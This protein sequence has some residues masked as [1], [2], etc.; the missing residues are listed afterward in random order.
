MFDPTL[1]SMPAVSSTKVMP[2]AMT[3]VKLA[4]LTMLASESRRRGSAAP[5]GRR[6]GSTA[7]KMI[8]SRVA[9][10]ESAAR[11][12][13]VAGHAATPAARK[14]A[15]RMASLSNALAGERADDLAA[16][17][18][19]D[20]V[21]HRHRLLDLGGDEAGCRSRRRRAG[22]SSCRSRSLAATS[23]PR[24]GSSRRMIAGPAISH[25]AMHH[26]LLVAARQ[27]L[28]R[29][30]GDRSGL[31]AQGRGHLAGAGGEASVRR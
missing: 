4:C 27:A 5:A 25:L 31:D 14:A 12:G 18:H 29:R 28:G 26:L 7:R 23:T 9:Q 19:Q 16:A 2:T 11:R 20:A 3:P 13:E 21:A 8:T 6:R 22:R 15:R 17:H 1:R 10:Q 24:V 30:R